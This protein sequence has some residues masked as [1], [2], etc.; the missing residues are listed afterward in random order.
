[1]KW[2]LVLVALPLL[3]YAQNSSVTGYLT[4]AKTGKPVQNAELLIENS[5]YA[6]TSGSDGAFHFTDLPAGSYSL[7]C[8][9]ISYQKQTIKFDLENNER[10]KLRISLLPGI[11]TLEEVVIKE[12]AP[13][14]ELIS[15]SHIPAISATRVDIDESAVADPGDFLRSL[16]NIS[17]IRKGGTGI[18]PVVRGFRFS[19]LNIQL[20]NGQKVEGGCPNRMD[21]VT[22]HIEI[23]DVERI[24]VYKGPHALKFG[25][26]LGGI[27]HIKTTGPEQ[28]D[29]PGFSLTAAKGYENNWNGEKERLSISAGVK[30][31]SVHISGSRRDYGNYKDGAG[32]IVGSSYCRYN[33]KAAVA[34][35]PD[36]RQKLA[37]AYE[38]SAGRNVA[39]PSLPMD[40]RTDDTRLVSVDYHN[41]NFLNARST[42]KVKIYDSH[43]HHLMDNK[44]RPLSDTVVAI[45][46]IIATNRGLRIEGNMLTG[47]GQITTGMDLEYITKDGSRTKNMI[48]Q[49]GLPVKEE[50][51]WNNA[52]Y[53]NTGL[54]GE[55]FIKH[56]TLSLTLSARADLNSAGSD[57]ISIT[58][59]MAGE[60][61]NYGT[62]SIRSDYLNFSISAG[63]VKGLGKKFKV[64]A[65]LGRG[66]RSPDLTERF[67][68]LLPI[69][70]DQFDYL[71]NPEIR[72]EINN[73]ADIT[74]TYAEEKTGMVEITG[75]I[76]Y[77]N[78]YI[79]GTI[80]PPSQ[81]KPLTANVLGV[82]RFDN[83]GNALLRGF[84][85]SYHSPER[86]RMRCTTGAGFTYGTLD[87]GYQYLLNENGEITGQ[88]EIKND[89]LSEIPP[90]EAT[91]ALE[92]PLIRNR[93]IPK[94][95]LRAV[96]PQNH[97]S[98]AQ[99]EM[100]SP[101]FV[102]AGVSFFFE[103]N[104][105]LSLTGGV[106]NIF[107]MAYYEHLNR[108]IIGSGSSF[109][110]P[111]RRFFINLLF[112]I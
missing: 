40:E 54:F 106:H 60:I 84:E 111:G 2:W 26:S 101:G 11:M 76:S 65:A 44:Q 5:S 102:I 27:V 62:D 66:M 53:S 82:K 61:Y 52:K 80:I 107:D 13:E 77:V 103:V 67:I 51:L 94:L 19:Q 36:S 34:W 88:Q 70:Y 38:G 85:F 68:I 49:P 69:G 33:Y 20:N 89:A 9:H 79:G 35:F 93:L 12:N 43:V 48:M 15:L 59:P 87:L 95:N 23:D 73:Q 104:S 30:K 112:K 72:P 78:R 7:V 90:L 39:F 24:D 21:P 6:T 56:N 91:L 81:Q 3:G 47:K 25:A 63:M 32:N 18:D 55:Y 29:K 58:H 22:S 100:A 98:K 16:S 97:I 110:E 8:R 28:F 57:E 41:N 108:N 86:F 37:G 105:V 14:R 31:A 4:E 74:F 10:K 64:A 42:L 45:S 17:G 75:F 50:K 1:M 96:A 71:G 46:D 92:Y 99:Y 109:Y 83:L